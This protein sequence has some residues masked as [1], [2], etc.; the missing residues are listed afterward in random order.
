MRVRLAVIALAA[1]VGGAFF[2]AGA[3]SVS[4]TQSAWGDRTAVSASVT[5][6]TWKTGPTLGCTAMSSAGKAVAGGT[7]TAT[8]TYSQWEDGRNV[9]RDYYV[10][11]SMS[12]GAAYPAVVLDLSTAKGSQQG[13]TAWVWKSPVTLATGQ[14]TLASGYTCS[15]LPVLRANGPS[16]GQSSTFWVRVVMDSSMPQASGK[17]CS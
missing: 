9:V 6:G 7:C 17:S 2:V 8:V 3:A 15:E 5:A 4:P 16:W 11:Y 12:S 13:S 14:Y 1:L 10:T